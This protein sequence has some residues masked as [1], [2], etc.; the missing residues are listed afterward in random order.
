M[1]IRTYV[2]QLHAAAPIHFQ[3][4]EGAYLVQAVEQIALQRIADLTLDERYEHQALTLC[5]RQNVVHSRGGIEDRLALPAFDTNFSDPMYTTSS[6][7][8]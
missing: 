3:T 8:S 4:F 6:P 1:Q 7:P 2:F 5:N